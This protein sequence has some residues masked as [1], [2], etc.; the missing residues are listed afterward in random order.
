M[1]PYK[2][3]QVYKQLTSQNSILKKYLKLGTKDLKQ[4]DLPAFVETKDAVNQFMLRNPRVEKAGG[5]M[6]VQPGFGGM[7]QGYRGPA[8]LPGQ[9][10]RGSF[11]EKQQ[12]KIKNAFPKTKFNFDDYKYGVPVYNKP[13]K[14]GGVNKDYTKVLRFIDKGFKIKEFKTDLLKIPDR[15]LIM[16]N[17]ELPQGV[18]EW[19]FNKYKYGIPGTGTD[20]ENMNLGKRISKYIKDK[21]AWTLATD[22]S[23]AKGWMMSAMERLYNNQ[24]GKT[25]NL[26][27]EPIFEKINGKKIIIG[28]KDNTESGKGK[29]Y[30]GLKK[31]EKKNNTPWI[32]H[33]DYKNVSKFVDISKR[34]F[35]EPNDVIKNILKQKGINQSLKLNDILNFDRYFE[36]LNKT[37]S[38][39]LLKNA[40]V[41]H[42]I[43]GVGGG[44]GSG[45]SIDIANAAAT[46]DLQ[47]LTAATNNKVRKIENKLKVNGFISAEDNLTLK[48]LGAS[49]RGADGKLYGGGSTTAI[50]GFKRIEKQAEEIVKGDKFNVKNIETYLQ[51]IGCPGL[52]SGG[53]AGFDVGTN[54]QMKGANL[55]NSGMRNASPA[56]LKNFAAFANRAKNLGRNVMKF[57]IIPEAMYVAADSA[58][59]L[60]M[61]DKPT[62]ALLRASE[63]VLPG[64]QTKLAEMMEA[65]RLSS[66]ETAAIIGRSI[67]YKNQ[68]AKIQ[69]LEDTRDNLENLSGGGEFDYIGDLNNDVRNVNNQI[70]QATNDL[71]TKFKMTD[72]E[73]IYANRMQDEVDDIRKSKSILTKLK[74][75]AQGIGDREYGDVETLGVPEKTQ[76]ELNKRM[77]PQIDRDLLLA[78]EEEMIEAA[79]TAQLQGYDIPDDYY[80][81]QQQYIKNLSLA[82]LA[83]A[84]NPEQVYGASGTMGEPLNK[85]PVEKK[86]NVISD[87]EREITGQTNVA[88]PFDIDLSMIGSGLRGFSA[89]GGGIAKEAGV[90]SGVPPESGP[91]PQGLSYL[92]KRGKN[93]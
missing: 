49:I 9:Y 89:A 69:G 63:Y 14:Q 5:G 43:S 72:A 86:Q 70:K 36:T 73:Q 57:G 28:F 33:G 46:K 82:E 42:H 2:L 55:I 87:M 83:A 50:G 12:T 93:I 13:G 78:S 31:Y 32:N 17:F 21:P 37:T 1:N 20:G 59:R 88:N 4:P 85:G 51:K 92:M 11:T 47:L 79:K 71:N 8:G 53:R 64:D 68:L 91:N 56:Q 52:A 35:N 76:E 40:I 30:Y 41:K 16:A 65:T 26:T 62:E 27:Y 18:N 67:D 24:K 45:R 38:K 54:C 23:S 48:N 34:S 66:P 19:N 39:E 7:R 22:R 44:T 74:S 90:D 61:G 60:T 10:D 58:I 81:K 84:T 3:S 25:K 80:I 29:T 77:T 75:I 15:N 6:L